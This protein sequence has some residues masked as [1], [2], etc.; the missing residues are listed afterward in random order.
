MWYCGVFLF[1]FFVFFGGRVGKCGK[2]LGSAKFSN[3]LKVKVKVV[4]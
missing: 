1:L 2:P 3:E 4:V